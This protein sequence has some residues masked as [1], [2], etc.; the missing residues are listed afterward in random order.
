MPEIIK[1]GAAEVAGETVFKVL[2]AVK[3][4]KEFKIV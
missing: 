2:K 3:R 1:A 4:A